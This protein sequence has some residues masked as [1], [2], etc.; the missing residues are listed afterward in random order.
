MAAM[1][2]FFMVIMASKARLAAARSGSV[3]ARV[4]CTGVICHEMPQRSLH[5]PQALSWPPWPTDGVPVAVGLGLVGGGDLEREGLAVSEGGP[6]VEPHAGQAEHGE[7][8]HQHVSLLAIGVVARRAVDGADGGIGEGGGV[9][10]RGCF[11]IAVEPQADGVAGGCGH[12]GLR[13][14][15]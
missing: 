4:S 3:Q 12:G 10:A 1:S 15:E 6:A 8:D 14:G 13:A 5:Q 11:G 7:L 9:E 2:I